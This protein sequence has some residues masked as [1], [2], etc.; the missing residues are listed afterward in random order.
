MTPATARKA[1]AC[2]VVPFPDGQRFRVG[3]A[4]EVYDVFPD[5]LSGELTC[6][7]RARSRCSHLIATQHYIDTRKGKDHA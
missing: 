6:S 5:I 2:I 3:G 4:T 1:I 7:C